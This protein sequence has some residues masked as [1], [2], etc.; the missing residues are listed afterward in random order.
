MR[1]ARP[2]QHEHVLEERPHAHADGQLN[3][4]REDKDR[5]DVVAVEGAVRSTVAPASRAVRT[6]AAKR[7]TSAASRG[8]RIEPSRYIR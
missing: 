5:D 6:P 7:S 3:E 8:K 1:A 2:V 4:T